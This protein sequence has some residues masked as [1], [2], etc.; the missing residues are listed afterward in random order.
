MSLPFRLEPHFP[1]SESQLESLTMVSSLPNI[2]TFARIVMVPLMVAAFYLPGAWSYWTPFALFVLAGLTDFLDGHLARRLAVTSDLGRLMDP[3]ADKLLV[4]AA[5]VMIVAAERVPG[6]GVWAAILILS[7]EF[8]ISGLR[9]FLS[10]RGIAVPVSQL[11][12]WKTAA[13]MVAIAVLLAGDGAG[14]GAGVKLTGTVLL[15][16]AA[17][18]SVLTAIDYLHRGWR[19]LQA[20]SGPTRHATKDGS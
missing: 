7:R 11:A 3:I 20:S 1:A 13:Q 15:W 4:A 8:V 5:L 19:A 16:A 2:L 9:E 12:K 14:L 10:M 18:L 6:H 17:G